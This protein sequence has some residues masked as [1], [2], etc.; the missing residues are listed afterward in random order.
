LLGLAG[1]DQNS[2]MT[3]TSFERRQQYR[4][5][6]DHV[7]KQESPFH[8]EDEELRRVVLE[9][10]H[11]MDFFRIIHPF[12]DMSKLTSIPDS[13]FRGSKSEEELE[14]QEMVIEA[15]TEALID[16]NLAPESEKPNF[17]ETRNGK[18]LD[19]LMHHLQALLRERKLPAIIRGVTP[20]IMNP[21]QRMFVYANIIE[22]I[23]FNNM[24]VK[25]LKVVNTRG[26]AFKTTQED[27]LQPA[28][29]T[30]L[31]GKISMIEVHIT[32]ERGKPVSFQ[33]GTVMLTLHFRRVI[34]SRGQRF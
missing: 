4:S 20:A 11:V 14:K 8:F 9:C 27:F 16:G 30:L 23:D 6:L 13:L 22:P 25:L 21:V 1:H 31:K 5:L 34:R 19:I 29:V 17:K 7:W 15:W 10:T 18:I 26:Q 32:D 33:S 2:N 3:M 28:Y 24:S 12:L